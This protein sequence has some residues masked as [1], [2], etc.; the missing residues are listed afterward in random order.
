MPFDTKRRI[1]A[2]RGK[3]FGS[4]SPNIFDTKPN[5]PSKYGGFLGDTLNPRMITPIFKMPKIKKKAI[6]VKIKKK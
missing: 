6:K 5:S 3:K 1:T 4:Q 2:S